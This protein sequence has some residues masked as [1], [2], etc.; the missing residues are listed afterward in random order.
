[1]FR[2]LIFLLQIK[3]GKDT[4]VFVG[5]EVLS[6]VVSSSVTREEQRDSPGGKN[7]SSNL[8][9]AVAIAYLQDKD[10]KHYF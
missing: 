10:S 5:V 8:A 2:W 4:A 9:Q 7:S 1:M 6:N 3:D